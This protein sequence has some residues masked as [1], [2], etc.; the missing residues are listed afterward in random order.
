MYETFKVMDAKDV[1]C[2][3]C[4]TLAD[5][6]PDCSQCKKTERIGSEHSPFQRDWTIFFVRF[7]IW[8]F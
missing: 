8:T 6:V 4:M 7:S 1:I 5:H 2:D 3:C